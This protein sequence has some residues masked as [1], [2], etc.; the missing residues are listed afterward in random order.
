[1]V[2]DGNAD[3]AEPGTMMG[4][5]EDM[6]LDRVHYGEDEERMMTDAME[7]MGDMGD[8]EMSEDMEIEHDMYGDEE[9]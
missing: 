7:F 3:G 4:D 8:M 6:M 9:E 2:T 1:M 5:M